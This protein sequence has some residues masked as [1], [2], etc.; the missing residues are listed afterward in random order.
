MSITRTT[1]VPVIVV[2]CDKGEDHIVQSEQPI[3][4]LDDLKVDYSSLT[5]DGEKSATG[6]IENY[7]FA[8]KEISFSKLNNKS[9]R[10]LHKKLRYND[11]R[12][13]VG[14]MDSSSSDDTIV[15]SDEEHFCN[16][17]PPITIENAE[18]YLEETAQ[19]CRQDKALLAAAKKML[20]EDR[21]RF[22]LS[23]TKQPK[24]RKNKKKGRKSKKVEEKRVS[25]DTSEW[26]SSVDDSQDKVSTT[27]TDKETLIDRLQELECEKSHLE[28]QIEQTVRDRED[29]DKAARRAKGDLDLEKERYDEQKK[30]Y[31]E[32]FKKFNERRMARE[33]PPKKKQ[34]PPKKEFKA[35]E[36]PKVSGK[37]NPSGVDSKSRK[38]SVSS[39]VSSIPPP[40]VKREVPQIKKPQQ[41]GRMQS[42][43]QEIFD[44]TIDNDIMRDKLDRMHAISSENP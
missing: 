23:S 42:D 24:K 35:P 37:K 4:S 26:A 44:L 14:S 36:Q 10:H 33:N 5:P 43:K 1:S 25:T 28:V 30:I 31:E 16:Y 17:F 41:Q 19:L 39:A 6:G 29:A 15:K 18:T 11:D 8:N 21:R 22:N 34:V 9:N 20:E 13:S 3:Y 12:N 2:T 38:S 40:P 32:E 7:S 27:S